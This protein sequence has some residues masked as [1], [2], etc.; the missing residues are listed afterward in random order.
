MLVLFGHSDE[1]NKPAKP[2]LLA[3]NLNSWTWEETI[4]HEE[5]KQERQKSGPL[6]PDA[7]AKKK[8]P[9]VSNYIVISSFCGAALILIVTVGGAFIYRSRVRKQQNQIF[10]YQ[11][12]ED[13]ISKPPQARIKPGEG[14]AG[15]SGSNKND[16]FM[17]FEDGNGGKS[18]VKVRKFFGVEQ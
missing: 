10:D 7:S 11:E 12:Q 16:G 13:L 18:G 14:N 2:S 15:L 17:W 6:M 1:T 4:N 8:D 9:P 5:L 3:L